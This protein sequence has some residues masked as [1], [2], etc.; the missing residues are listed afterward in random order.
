MSPGKGHGAGAGPTRAGKI[1]LGVVFAGVF[2]IGASAF[3]SGL[4]L[5]F[6]KAYANRIGAFFA[7]LLGAGLVAAS[8]W[9]FYRAH[10]A[11]PR[12]QARLER[13]E[14]QYPGQPWMARDDWAA[15]RVTHTSSGLATFLW[16]WT[17]GW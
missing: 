4:S 9:Y 1:V 6:D 13:I 16:I 2:L 12:R 3:Q 11:G 17:F 5:L 7:V 15:R 8:V 10:V 14:K